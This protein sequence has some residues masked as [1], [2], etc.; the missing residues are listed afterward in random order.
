M[1]YTFKPEINPVSNRIMA[2]QNRTQANFASNQD[3][4]NKTKNSRIEQS[5][6]KADHNSELSCPFMPTLVAR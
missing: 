4:W 2:T 6:K 5:R 3:Q 1:N